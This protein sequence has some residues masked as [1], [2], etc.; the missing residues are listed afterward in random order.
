MPKVLDYA[1][2]WLSRP[3]PG[4]DF[5]L[6]SSAEPSSPRASRSTKARD[7]ADSRE[8]PVGPKRTIARR[9]NEVFA[10]VDNQI[11]W[12]NLVTLKDD[13][14]TDVRQRRND[15]VRGNSRTPSQT[16]N[17]VEDGVTSGSH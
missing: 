8:P 14:Q 4:A 3:S 13:W 10:L 7:V 17:G 6:S 9:G 15:T 12:T 1:P 5:F 16:V 11:R 2:P